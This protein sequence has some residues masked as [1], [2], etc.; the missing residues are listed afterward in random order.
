VNGAAAPQLR[1]PGET[2]RLSRTSA[3]APSLGKHL[4]PDGVRG[5][6]LDLSVKAPGPLWPPPW[7]NP[8]TPVMHV[9]VAQFGLGSYERYLAGDGESFLA[10]AQGA[11]AWL[12][13]R[14]IHGGALDGGLPHE[15]EMPHTYRLAPG[16]LSSMAQG[17][18]ASLLVRLQLETG[19]ME[20]G[21]A[22]KRSLSPLSVPTGQGGV[23]AMLEDGPFFE[24]YPTRPASLVLNG[25]IFTLWGVRDVAIGLN[26]ADA[27]ELLRA[28]I[29][30]LAANLDRWDTGYWSRYDLFPHPVPNIASGSYHHLHTTQLKAMSLISPL[31][32]FGE[33]GDR[34]SAYSE[35]RINPMRAAAAKVGFRLLV[36]R[37]RLLAQRLPWLA[38][39]KRSG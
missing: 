13:E 25:E 1:H 29:D 10:A 20:L 6:Y 30:T 17:Q 28:A 3:F 8:D 26:D 23:L 37:N 5:Y 9:T 35:R 39:R 24:E 14:Q 32:A 7:M 18:A 15:F 36:P 4:D 16:W 2:G 11:G 38:R 34:F 31:A 22:A 19:D 12:M 21:E 27:G 33:V